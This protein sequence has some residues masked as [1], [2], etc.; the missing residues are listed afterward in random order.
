M[1]S[2]RL[3][4]NL[5]VAS[6]FVL[7]FVTFSPVLEAEFVNWDDE[8]NYVENTEYQGLT[9][10]HLRWMFTTNFLGHYQPLTWLTYGIDHSIGAR[11]D[12]SPAAPRWHLTSLL[13]HAA[14]SVVLFLLLIE[15]FRH[16]RPGSDPPVLA[17]LIGCLFFS[18]HPLRTEPVAWQSARGF[19]ICGV[20]YLLTIYAWLRSL[21][22]ERRR[23]AWIAVASLCCLL[24]W[25][26]REWAVTLPAVLLAIDIYPL[27]RL[28]ANPA[29]A[30]SAS[31][32]GQGFAHR[33]TGLILEK[34][35]YILL[36]FV[37]GFL[38]WWARQN[39][40]FLQDFSMHGPFT[41]FM[42]SLQHL[43]F[44]I[45]K[46][47]NPTGLYP[48]YLE[49]YAF[50]PTEP[51]YFLSAA[52]LLLITVVLLVFHRM[53]RPALVAWLLY[54]LILVPVVGIAQSSMYIAADRYSYF[55]VLPFSFLLVTA[56][57]RLSGRR[58]AWGFGLLGLALVCYMVLSHRQSRVWQDSLALWNH[59]IAIDPDNAL[60]HGNRGTVY[61]KMGPKFA[62]KAKEDFRRAINY[63]RG[64]SQP[65]NNLG[66]MLM[67]DGDL[68][69]AQECFM[70]AY[71]LAQDKS[72]S[73]VHLGL[74]FAAQGDLDRAEKYLSE[75]LH[76]NPELPQAYYSRGKVYVRQKR[77]EE[78]EADFNRAIAIQPGES[79]YYVDRGMMYRI[80]GRTEE[81][82]RDI[83]RS[84]DLE[85]EWEEFYREKGIIE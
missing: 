28:R 55:A 31:S 77:Y 3:R 37:G 40:N 10:D 61:M 81:A 71:E 18:L 16:V 70:R 17:A 64:L 41:R 34:T 75:A 56:L 58:V 8:I 78:A 21:R 39:N 82:T 47:V 69:G 46:T 7:P 83:G 65:Y 68:E 27:K 66:I 26:A 80:L 5:A 35:P 19:V 6:A 74:I 30:E 79:I 25:L 51:R 59:T 45:V 22:S 13:W 54:L 33:A 63:N 52:G 9:P 85:P 38:G 11:P 53:L 20:F 84:M 32:Q 23:I 15:F 49:P 62:E 76:H 72:K 24:A 4:F 12:G 67:H 60:A 44:Y 14:S 42:Q 43:M 50:S 48:A 36:T 73:F 2:S 29:V 1:A 57:T